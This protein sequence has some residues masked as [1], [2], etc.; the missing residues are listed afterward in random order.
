MP[1]YKDEAHGTFYA[2]FYYTDFTGTK[3]KKMKR[4][5]KLKRDA[6]EWE[7]Q[8]L[9]QKNA[10]PD[11]R[12]GDFVSIYRSEKRERI[13]EHTWESK[14]NIIDTKILPYFKDR[15]LSEIE[16]RD[17][18]AW[19]NTLM[20]IR[21]KN[22]KP[23]SPTYLKSIHSQL[24]AIFNYAV[25]Y[26][27][28]KQNPAEI[29]GNMGKETHK[30]MLFWTKAEYLQFAQAMMDKPMSYYAFEMLY[31]CGIRMGELLALTPA[32]FNFERFTLT[33]NKSY[34]RLKGQDVIT[35][36]KTSK[37]NRVIRIPRFLAEEM[38]DYLKS[39][40]GLRS[41][42]RIF[43]I[44]K[45]YLHHEMDRGAKQAGVRRIRI[46]DLR[47]SHVSLLIEMGFSAVAIAERVGHESIDITLMRFFEQFKRGKII[48]LNKEIHLPSSVDE[49]VF[50]F[51]QHR[52]MGIQH[53]VY[54]LSVLFKNKSVFLTVY[55]FLK[56]G[57]VRQEIT[58]VLVLWCSR[59]K[60]SDFFGQY[61][62]EDEKS[63][64]IEI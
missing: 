38:Q 44:T 46:H 61:R 11:M 58:C 6:L 30:E 12:F 52:G 8:F 45:N 47:H 53:F 55:I 51:G 60:G 43:P 63:G 33:I 23:Y 15:T 26:Y 18:I 22:G 27:R 56:V 19:Q 39:L 32:D 2:S 14:D 41:T 64:I 13:R 42:D 28:L 37:S 50:L 5:F 57:K 7:R 48:S 31:W 34:Q 54:F 9:L 25:K 59:N 62:T 49:Q 20:G 36:P 35:A 10:D 1:A 40:Y 29:A 17:V 4:G 21:Q 3:R 16:P 24:S